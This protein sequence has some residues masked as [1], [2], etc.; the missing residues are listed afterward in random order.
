VI[1][2]GMVLPEERQLPADEEGAE[3]LP[4]NPLYSFT[5]KEVRNVNLY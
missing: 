1:G 3:V 2:E 4:E 5:A